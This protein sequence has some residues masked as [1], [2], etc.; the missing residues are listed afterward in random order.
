MESTRL[1]DEEEDDAEWQRSAGD[2]HADDRHA[3]YKPPYCRARYE[4]ACA[5]GSERDFGEDEDDDEEEAGGMSVMDAFEDFNLRAQKQMQELLDA[6]DRKLFDVTTQVDTRNEDAPELPAHVYMSDH[7]RLSKPPQFQHWRSAFSYLQVTGCAMLSEP[8]ED[9]ICMAPGLPQSAACGSEGVEHRERTSFEPLAVLGRHC[10]TT[11]DDA[12][13]LTEE[14]IL[15]DGS[16]EEIIVHDDQS[17]AE[18]DTGQCSS[19]G[20]ASPRTTRMLEAVDVL[21]IDCFSTTVVSLMTSFFQA[22]LQKQQT[23]LRKQREAVEY[24]ATRTVEEQLAAEQA[25]RVREQLRAVQEAERAAAIL[26]AEK[27]EAAREAERQEL[28][29]QQQREENDD[30]EVKIRTLA[31]SHTREW[32]QPDKKC[33]SHRGRQLTYLKPVLTAKV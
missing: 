26:K 5:S 13:E 28:L 12:N 31:Y 8:S 10:L 15:A 29:R 27:E 1:N 11:P 6:T 17:D 2:A 22:L 32:Y 7:F 25:E 14:T 19:S 24:A 3:G 9:H 23:M 16:M 18:N 20:C 4:E 21:T 30:E 33:F